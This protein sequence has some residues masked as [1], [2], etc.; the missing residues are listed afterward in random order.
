MTNTLKKLDEQLDKQ[1]HS[2]QLINDLRQQLSQ[3]NKA[4]PMINDIPKQLGEPFFVRPRPTDAFIVGVLRETLDKCESNEHR[5]TSSHAMKDLHERL[6]H[7]DETVKQLPDQIN[8]KS[9]RAVPDDE[10]TQ[11]ANLRQVP[12]DQPATPDPS[13]L[14]TLSDGQSV[15][16]VANLLALQTAIQGSDSAPCQNIQQHLKRIEQSSLVHNDR[17]LQKVS[18]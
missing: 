14:T 16:L 18:R 4:L 12:L 8:A 3:L 9:K 15:N 1:Q 17:E 10:R 5:K 11:A 7:L 13:H 2:E 6:R